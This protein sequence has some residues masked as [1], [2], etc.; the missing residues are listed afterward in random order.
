MNDGASSSINKSTSESSNSLHDRSKI[1]PLELAEAGHHPELD[2]PMREHPRE[3]WRLK[4][5]HKHP[6]LYARFSQVVEYLRGPRPKIDLPDPVPWLDVDVTIK[7]HHI[8]IPVESFLIRVTNPFTRPWLILLLGAAYIVALSFFSRAQS[9]LTPASSFIGCTSTYWLSQ[10]GCGLDGQSCAPFNDSSLDF[11][12]PAQCTSTI[13]QNPRTVGNGQIAFVPLIVGGGDPEGTYRSDSFICAA[14]VQAGLFRDSRGGC[15]SLELIG[16]F[17]NFLPKKAHGLS[18]IGFDTVFPSAFRFSASTTLTH[19]EDHRDAALAMNLLVTCF[20]FLVLRPKAIVKFWCLV[21]IGYWHSTLFSDPRSY[22][23]TLSDSFA[24]FLPSL[25][26]C[27]GLWRVAFRF[28]LPA[29]AKAPIESTVWYLGPFWVGIYTNLTTDKL[30]IDRLTASDLTK[31]SGAITALVVIVLIVLFFALN[32]ARVIRKTGWLP[33]YLG[34]YA[35][36]G[37]V[38]LVLALLPT[39]NLR[40][41]H[42][43]LAIC[44]VPG[45][46]FPTRV[47]AIL[48]GYLLGM[49]LN[50]SAVF[51]LDSILQTTAEL[52]QDAPIG[53][54]LP[55][56][57]TNS[58]TFNSSIPFENQTIFWD[59]LPST[60]WDGFSLLV[61]DVERY[62]GPALNFSLAVFNSS[63]PH[64]FRL[65]FTTGGNTGDFTKAATLWPNMT[66]QDPSPGPS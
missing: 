40:I 10:N 54:D 48:Q 5:A 61:D 25:F 31:R 16:N 17:T 58:T 22:P 65:A 13:L 64:F 1:F 36:G 15:G 60:S 19:C 3:P 12:C 45:L 62:V 43:F 24:D 29:F 37:L 39:F 42:Y 9:F 47:S 52:R 44:L 2:T 30:P 63:L 50:G 18:S 46:G 21:C 33:H 11:R 32:Q 56:F 7:S 26:I 38:A 14:A 23:P 8:S 53:S 49:F 28:T 55:A 57:L 51:G 35:L 59:I 6:T 66:W 34:W 4:L 27:Y 20:I 41:H